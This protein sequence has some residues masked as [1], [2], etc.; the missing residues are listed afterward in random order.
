MFQAFILLNPRQLLINNS[1]NSPH[2][3]DAKNAL[4]AVEYEKILTE[5]FLG[6]CKK[7]NSL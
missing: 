1:S 3:K 2:K 6:S 4:A 5:G 7:K